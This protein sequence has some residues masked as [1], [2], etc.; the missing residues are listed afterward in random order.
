MS[1][2][3]LVLTA[4]LIFTLSL[5]RADEP[6]RDRFGDPL[7]AGA[8]ARLGTV[9]AHPFV[10]EVAFS[11]DG[12]T[13][14]TGSRNVVRHWDASTG[15]V[16]RRFEHVIPADAWNQLHSADGRTGATLWRDHLDIYD[17]ETNKLRQRVAL[18]PF[19]GVSE[20]VIAPRG[21]LVVISLQGVGNRS[22]FALAVQ[23]NTGK[24]DRWP[25]TALF[26]SVLSP[27]GDRLASTE[28]VDGERKVCIRDAA[29]KLLYRLPFDG[30]GRAFSPDGA[31]LLAYD[32]NKVKLM[33]VDAATGAI[34]DVPL[35]RIQSH[36]HAA[37][38]PDGR[39]LAVE[40]IG[41]ISL[42]DL[43]AR[44]AVRQ[45]KA[46]ARALAFSPDGNRLAA[47]DELMH[48]WDIET[49]KPLWP[50]FGPLL[51]SNHQIAPFF[52][53][54]AGKSL[55]TWDDEMHR[56]QVWDWTTGNSLF[57]SPA[58]DGLSREAMWLTPDGAR[59]LVCTEEQVLGWELAGGKE[60]HNF[61]T[62]PSVVTAHD[63]Y[64]A[65]ESPD[66]KAVSVLMPKPTSGEM[67]RGWLMRWDV[68]TGRVIERPE[69]EARYRDFLRIMP[70]GRHVSDRDMV[71]DAATGRRQ[72]VAVAPPGFEISM[73]LDFS[74][75]GRLAVSNLRSER[76]DGTGEL[77]V[78]E[79]ATGQ[80]LLR[81]PTGPKQTIQAALSPDDRWLALAAEQSIELWDLATGQRAAELKHRT[82]DVVQADATY[83]CLGLMFLPGRRLIAAYGDRTALVWQMPP[84]TEKPPP[85]RL[86][87]RTFDD[88]AAPEPRV[89]QDAVW[90]LVNEPVKA[91][92]LLR[93]RIKPAEAVAV[94]DLTPLI[95]DLAVN[96]FARRE[97]AFRRLHELGHAIEK[98]LEAAAVRVTNAEQSR[99][100]KTLLDACRDDGPM[101]AAERRA[102]RAI[103]ALG[104]F[105]TADARAL[106]ESW[107]KGDATAI[108]TRE[109]KAALERLR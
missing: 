14:I 105:D 51:G 33:L 57:V 84:E 50:E 78:W 10:E 6:R 1:R 58:V 69:F 70:D 9:H 90:A 37:F 4:V 62:K 24:M 92:E 23:T 15:R 107:S 99:R 41:S 19:D 82:P 64:V 98:L 22:P 11:A 55:T 39:L 88:L 77:V 31:K 5:A 86:S 85:Q 44:K 47:A 54:P 56:L 72:R 20:M 109:A 83:Y 73:P 45:W 97:A 40:D 49:G 93:E 17:V 27:R 79:T 66:G 26:R 103:Q 25:E 35:P 80:P 89:A 18:P 30:Q 7:P 104:L 43:H 71:R 63:R 76:I 94:N 81:R 59:A 48:C 28:L 108:L 46:S 12:K 34:L 2:R 3:Q 100:L 91:I 68:A 87:E 29:G 106:I 67:W 13:L 61:R 52:S 65:R 60:V 32:D 96:N 42:W 95:N 101:N 102:L 8:I 74:A 21:D 16:I 53:R 75:D 38:S 36:P